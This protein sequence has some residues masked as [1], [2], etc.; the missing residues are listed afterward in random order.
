MLTVV[1]PPSGGQ[2]GGAPKRR[3]WAPSLSLTPEEHRALAATLRSLRAALGSWKAVSAAMGGISTDTLSGVA[4]DRY[5]GSAVLILRAARVAR[6][7]VEAVLSPGP[8]AADR[9]P[10]CGARR[11]AP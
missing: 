3:R 10:H 4:G 5:P 7:T 9:C 11:G 2:G 6:T 1:P 8:R